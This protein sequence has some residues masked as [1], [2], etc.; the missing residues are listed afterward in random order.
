MASFELNCGWMSQLGL[1]NHRD[2]EIFARVGVFGLLP[3]TEVLSD[4]MQIGLVQYKGHK[5]Q[6]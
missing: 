6:I 5:G 4:V 1:F 2:I 3:H